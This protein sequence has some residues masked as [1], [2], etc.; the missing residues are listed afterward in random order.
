MLFYYLKYY[1]KIK[2]LIIILYAFWSYL[3]KIYMK[4]SIQYYIKKS[5]YYNS[6]K[7]YDRINIE[8]KY[9]NEICWNP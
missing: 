1:K 5:N 6:F 8:S 3:I 4:I 7:W 2:L 9:K